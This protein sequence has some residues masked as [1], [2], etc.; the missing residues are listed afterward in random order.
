MGDCDMRW[1]G[2]QEPHNTTLVGHVK[3][4]DFYLNSIDD[5]GKGL[6]E[7]KEVLP[8]VGKGRLSP[9]AEKSSD[10]VLDGCQEMCLSMGVSSRRGGRQRIMPHSHSSLRSWL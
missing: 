3:A 2:S 7:Q 1:R 9:G 6:S 5:S 8:H 10:L 4:F